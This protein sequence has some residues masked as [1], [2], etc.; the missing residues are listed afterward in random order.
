MNYYIY[1][2]YLDIKSNG[3][4]EE[5]MITSVID[6]SIFQSSGFQF[7]I[8]MISANNWKKDKIQVMI[9]LMKPE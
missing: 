5:R 2:A 4:F 8:K 6:F 3:I 9:F 7:S 1:I